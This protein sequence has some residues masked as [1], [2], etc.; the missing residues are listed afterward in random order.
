V[1]TAPTKSEQV[2]E[3]IVGLIE[4]ELRAHDRLPTERDLAHD[5]AVSR[6]TVR[7]V[8][9]RLENEG[10]VYRVQGAG[11]FVSELRI[12]KSLE[13][14]SFSEDMR[15]RGLTPGS[16]LIG[17]VEIPAGARLGFELGISPS[18]PVVH[19]ARVRTA[20]GV[21]MCIEHSYLPASLVPGLVK[22]PLTGSLYE[23]LSTVFRLRLERAEQTIRSTVLEPSDAGLLGVPAF[24]PAL[25][26]ERTCYDARGRAVERAESLYRGDRYAYTLTLH[27]TRSAS[28]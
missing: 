21:P 19:V 5:L 23:T 12:A 4:T 8:L 14:S 13:L 26:V 11:T 24:S 17:V 6:L 16:E 22:S 20:D 9:D 25:A 15:G 18:E 7:R 2:R 3:H 10:R 27:H 28:S 1:V